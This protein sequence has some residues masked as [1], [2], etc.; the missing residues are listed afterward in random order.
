[1]QAKVL[2]SES[3]DGLLGKMLMAWVGTSAK[4]GVRGKRGRIQ[5]RKRKIVSGP[6][7][8]FG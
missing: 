4:K 2:G 3:A 8:L 6:F 1:V 7:V 5:F